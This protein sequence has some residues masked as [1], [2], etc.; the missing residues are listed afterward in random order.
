MLKTAGNRVFA[1]LSSILNL[2]GSEN[3]GKI[4]IGVAQPVYPLREVVESELI[5]PGILAYTTEVNGANDTEFPFDP[6]ESDTGDAD[7]RQLFVSQAKGSQPVLDGLNVS[8]DFD[9]YLCDFG[10]TAE[11]S[12]IGT[13]NVQ[14]YQMYTSAISPP[15]PNELTRIL[16]SGSGSQLVA[17]SGVVSVVG[18]ARLHPSRPFPIRMPNEPWANGATERMFVHHGSSPASAISIVAAGRLIICRKGVLPTFP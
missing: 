16:W 1:R 11:S 15:T 8:R 12:S 14:L 9:A 13:I 4:D 6:F 3:L 7:F 17:A 2:P 5:I 10:V 18:Q